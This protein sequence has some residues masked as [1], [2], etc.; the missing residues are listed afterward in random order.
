MRI[1]LRRRGVSQ[2]VIYLLRRDENRQWKIYGW[3]R[4][5]NVNMGMESQ[6]GGQSGAE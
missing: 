2:D 5:Q 6:E 3:D 1:I 4:A